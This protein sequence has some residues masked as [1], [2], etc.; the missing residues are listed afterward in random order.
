MRSELNEIQHIEFYLQGKLDKA[1]RLAFEK[2]MLFDAGFRQKV[3]LQQQL[4][5]GVK[6][7]ALRHSIAKAYR[8]FSLKKKL[9]WGLGGAGMIIAV[10]GIVIAL[11]FSGGSETSFSSE[12]ME[13]SVTVDGKE[14]ASEDLAGNTLKNQVFTIQGDQD[15]VIQSKDGILFA[16]EAGTFINEDG[17]AIDGEIKVAVKEALK[18]DDIF[19]K[20]QYC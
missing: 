3:E 5:Q 16:I 13:P 20:K 18:V 8:K 15:T 12:T 7:R 19:R 17:E 1:Q 6:N 14:I 2:K 10:A 11:Q 4:M 9:K